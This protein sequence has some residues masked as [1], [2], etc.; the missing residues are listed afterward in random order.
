MG[1]NYLE[2]REDIWN[3]LSPY[4]P[5]WIPSDFL[6]HLIWAKDNGHVKHVE[7]GSKGKVNARGGASISFWDGEIHIKLADG[8]STM[9][10]VNHF[11]TPSRADEVNMMTQNTLRLWWD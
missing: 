10:V 2:T 7:I 11:I 6:K 1:T 5:S 9:F 8:A 4:S 3:A